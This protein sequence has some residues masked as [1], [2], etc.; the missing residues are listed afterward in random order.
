[1]VDARL[2]VLII[3]KDRFRRVLRGIN[4]TVTQVREGVR[5]LDRTRTRRLN[6][7]FT[8]LRTRIRQVAVAVRTLGQRVRAINRATVGR[9]IAGFRTLRGTTDAAARSAGVLRGALAPFIGAAALVIGIIS[10]TRVLAGFGQQ[11]A[12][13]RAITGATEQQFALLENEARRLGATT[14]FTAQ[15]AADGL[16]FLARAG[17]SAE[18]ATEAL[19][20][21]LNLASAGMLDLASSADIVSN[22]I[23]QF[24]LDTAETNRVVDVLAVTAANSNTN[25]F[26]LGEAFKFVGPIARALNISVEDTSELLGL[27]GNAGI[28]ASNAGAG[29]RRAFFG[30]INTTPKA[31]KALATL[32][33]TTKD[34]QLTG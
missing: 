31:A 17:F 32:G 23:Q 24:G 29:L 22:V 12:A 15:Q 28:Q 1:M 7:T 34:V 16:E 14:R 11:M 9:L 20:G 27:L 33:L 6:L 30:L 8:K 10:A 21:T 26:Q 4:R 2:E 25:V 5:R 18:D 13:V 19:E 3:A